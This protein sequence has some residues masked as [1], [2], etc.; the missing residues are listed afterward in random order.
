MAGWNHHEKIET[1]KEKLDSFITENTVF[2]IVYK[3]NN[4][5]IGSLG[6]NKYDMEE[7]L[8]EFKNL[9]GREIG[10]ILSKDY[11]WK[12][13]MPEAVK[14][15]INYLFDDCNL[16]FII[17]GYYLFNKQ[18]QRVQEK[19]SFKSYRYLVMDTKR[20]TK[21]KGILNLLLNSKKI[22]NYIFHILKL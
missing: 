6:V 5:V 13:L 3:E 2:A 12:S 20:G 9:Y 4:K 19:Y 8:D 18:S 17:C 16:D 11:W 7:K 21:E 22:L 15:V 10:Y 14:G 1:T